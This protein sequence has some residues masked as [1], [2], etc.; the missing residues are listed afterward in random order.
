[1]KKIKLTIEG[2]HCASCANNI[3]LSLNRLDG[4]QTAHVSF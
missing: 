4:I 1:M 3:E 2:M